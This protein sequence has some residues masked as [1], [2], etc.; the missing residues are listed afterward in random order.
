MK[1]H[2]LGAGFRV[3]GRTDRHD[4]ANSRLSQF[5]HRAYTR[6]DATGTICWHP[7]VTD[8]GLGPTGRSL[9]AAVT[10]IVKMWYVM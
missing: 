6:T 8:W 9:S 3:D 1:I 5:C 7:V 10:A 4:V 2:T